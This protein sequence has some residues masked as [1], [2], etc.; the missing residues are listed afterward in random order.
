MKT[1]LL[2]M[3]IFFIQNTVL[4]TASNG[5]KNWAMNKQYVAAER[6]RASQVGAGVYEAQVL[7]RPA[8]EEVILKEIRTVVY[9]VVFW[10]M[11][12]C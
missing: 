4:E 7:R 6:T 8:D 11:V 3:M 1:E 5:G 2:L 10:C 9:A 12:M